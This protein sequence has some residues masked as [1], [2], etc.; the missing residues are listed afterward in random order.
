MKKKATLITLTV[1]LAVVCAG[2]LSSADAR[3][4][5]R[6]RKG[7]VSTPVLQP[8]TDAERDE[9]FFI[10]EEEKLARDVYIAMS[11]IYDVPIFANIAVSEQKHMDAILGLLVKY[12]IPDPAAENGAGEF[13]DAALQDLYN[14]LVERGRQSVAEAYAVGVDIETMDIQDLL[15]A[16]EVTIDAGMD[17]AHADI[18][19]VYS[20]IK[21]GSER[22]LAAFSSHLER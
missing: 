3:Q 5:G 8:V 16:I 12:G 17:E 21:A 4:A 11:E 14:I 7:A 13:T 6:T 18:V 22:H 15:E 2:F 19:T 20:N 10:R 9:M 1:L